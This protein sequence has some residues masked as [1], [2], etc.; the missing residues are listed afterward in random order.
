MQAKAWWCGRPEYF[1]APFAHGHRALWVPGLKHPIIRLGRPNP[2][3]RK[4]Q[5]TTRLVTWIGLLRKPRDRHCLRQD[6][7]RDNEN[8]FGKVTKLKNCTIKWRKRKVYR[9][10][11]KQYPHRPIKSVRVASESDARSRPP[12]HRIGSPTGRWFRVL[13]TNPNW[14]PRLAE[15]GGS[16][17][18]AGVP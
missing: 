2:R 6:R 3:E 5:E 7:P 16:G 14:S 8:S 17:K 4:I 18:P 9:T 12:E 13:P 1:L 15:A 11:C 10:P